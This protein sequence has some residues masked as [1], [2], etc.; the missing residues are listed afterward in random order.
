MLGEER[1]RTAFLPCRVEGHPDMGA[2]KRFDDAVMDRCSVHVG[3]CMKPR[4]V[5]PN[6][7]CWSGIEGALRRNSGNGDL[8]CGDTLPLHL[9]VMNSIAAA[10]NRQV[11]IRVR[12]EREQRRNQRKAEEQQ[13]RKCKNASHTAIVA[14]DR[15][16]IDIRALYRCLLRFTKEVIHQVR[17]GDKRRQED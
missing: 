13:E 15:C 7:S 16:S 17:G 4:V 11:R 5:V 9:A 2:G 8:L 3:A 10:A 12:G 6:Q 14:D 1:G